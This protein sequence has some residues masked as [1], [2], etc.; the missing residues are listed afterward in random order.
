MKIVKF[1]NNYYDEN[2]Y[3]IIDNKKIYIIDPGLNGEEIVSFLKQNNYIPNIIFLTH[4]H[5]DHT[6]DINLIYNYYKDIVVYINEYD[7][8]MLYDPLLNVSG[9]RDSFTL[10]KDIPVVKTTDLDCIEGFTFYHSKGHTKGSIIIKYDKYL[11]TGDTLFK[12]GVGRIDLPTGNIKEMRD[13][14]IS[15]PKKFSFNS[16]IL[17]GHGIETT[18]KD[19]YKTN[20]YL[21]GERRGQ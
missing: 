21:N 14:L 8:Q 16:V 19:E 13:T 10:Y 7:F 1:N 18:L 2:S 12:D 20:H 3:L 5:F 6:K 11:F 9:V 17:P 4:G 15:I